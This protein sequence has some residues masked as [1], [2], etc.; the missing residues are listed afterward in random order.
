MAN[1]SKALERLLMQVHGRSLAHGVAEQPVMI[2]APTATLIDDPM[3]PVEEFVNMFA[4]ANLDTNQRPPNSWLKKQRGRGG[5]VRQRTSGVLV[6]DGRRCCM[7]HL[8]EVN[9]TVHK[10]TLPF[11][12][13]C[14]KC[15]ATFEIDQRVRRAHG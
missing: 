11:E 2:N 14:P 6:Y 8:D 9:R 12:T 7:E 5:H 15:R 13:I 4:D 3:R 1:R 10:R